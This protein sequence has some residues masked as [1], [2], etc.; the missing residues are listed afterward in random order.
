MLGLFL[1]LN[2]VIIIIII[3]ISSS[4]T[5][6][7]SLQKVYTQYGEVFLCKVF[8]MHYLVFL[9]FSALQ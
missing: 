5:L 3:I 2:T 1:S 4:I 9:L 6:L 8:V 7:H